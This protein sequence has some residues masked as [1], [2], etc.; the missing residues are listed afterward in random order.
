MQWSLGKKKK[1]ALDPIMFGVFTEHLSW[2]KPV[3]EICEIT[4]MSVNGLRKDLYWKA[5]YLKCSNRIHLRRWR[6]MWFWLNNAVKKTR[7]KMHFNMLSCERPGFMLAYGKKGK[8]IWNIP[9]RGNLKLL[10]CHIFW[11]RFYACLL[12]YPIFNIYN[13]KVL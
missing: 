7:F 12:L 6:S 2:P 8:F 11:W 10:N 13:S 3:R 9:W 5:M 4:N 1:A